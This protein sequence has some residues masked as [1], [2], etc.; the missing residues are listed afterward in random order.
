MYLF[1]TDYEMPDNWDLIN[2]ENEPTT[3]VTGFER[4]DKNRLSRHIFIAV[5]EPGLVSY[6]NPNP[7]FT[8]LL[9]DLQIVHSSNIPI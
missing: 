6:T 2:L 8:H 5:L 1:E 7:G 4:D 3:Y 9:S